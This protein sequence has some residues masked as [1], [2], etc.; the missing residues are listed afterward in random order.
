[1]PAATHTHK[2]ETANNRLVGQVN[3]T[4]SLT[5]GQALIA[6]IDS[7][8]ILVSRQYMVCMHICYTYMQVSP[9]TSLA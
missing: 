6:M 7:Y 8:Q 4:D 3:M 5:S 9:L 2:S 1:M